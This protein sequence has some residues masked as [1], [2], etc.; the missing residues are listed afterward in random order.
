MSNGSSLVVLKHTQAIQQLHIHLLLKPPHPSHP[1]TIAPNTLIISKPLELL[2]PR[3]TNL[4]YPF[5]NTSNHSLNIHHI[6]PVSHVSGSQPLLVVSQSEPLSLKILLHLRL[7]LSYSLRF[8][9]EVEDYLIVLVAN[10]LFHIAVAGWAEQ[11]EGL[12]VDPVDHSCIGVTALGDRIEA[13]A[14]GF[15]V[16]AFAVV[17][18]AVAVHVEAAHFCLVFF[19]LGFLECDGLGRNGTI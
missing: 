8:T 5:L 9:L 15:E 19:F 4:L 14:T 2:P 17:T 6:I 1:S 13:V 18:V 11:R 3:L 10:L 7:H 12:V 16:G